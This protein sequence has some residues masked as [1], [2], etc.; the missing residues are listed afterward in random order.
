MIFTGE[1]KAKLERHLDAHELPVGLGTEDSACSIAAINLAISGK[2]TDEIPECM[3]LVIGKWI[4]TM[5]DKMPDDLRNSK[6]WK[7]LLPLAAGTGREIEE[8][9]LAVCMD[10][11]WESLEEIQSLADKQGFGCEWSAMLKE[12]TKAAAYAAYAAYAAAKAVAR[13]AAYDTG[14]FVQIARP[15]ETL[16]AMINVTGEMK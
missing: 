9:R 14:N 3:S 13:A 1:M 10:M 11:M 7:A 2:L 8:E 4:I 5:Q 16:A 6:E 12:K 15:V